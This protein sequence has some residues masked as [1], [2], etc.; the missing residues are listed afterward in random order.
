MAKSQKVHTFNF[1]LSPIP[2][3]FIVACSMCFTFGNGLASRSDSVLKL[4]KF[5]KNKSPQ[6]RQK[7]LLLNNSLR[8]TKRLHRLQYTS[9]QRKNHRQNQCNIKCKTPSEPIRQTSHITHRFP[10]FFFK[11]KKYS[12]L[13]LT[14]CLLRSRYLFCTTQYLLSENPAKT[15]YK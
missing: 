7:C 13:Q 10:C 14:K 9:L 5:L 12:L 4:L 2:M 11:Q 3:Y 1:D 6:M 15:C 8:T